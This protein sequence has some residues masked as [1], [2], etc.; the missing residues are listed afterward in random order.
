MQGIYYAG[1]LFTAAERNWNAAM[2]ERLRGAFPDLPI[3]V[4]QE[5]CTHLQNDAGSPDFGEI[6]HACRE[7]IDRSSILIAVLDGSDADSGTAWELGYA[8]AKGL[9][10]FGLRTDWRPAE[11]GSANC[12]LSRSCQAVCS[13]I[14]KLIASL[15]DAA[16]PGPTRP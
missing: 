4:P 15:Q 12:M 6:F 7:H 1:P 9:R 11:D 3:H 14:E 13:S 5:F 10:C 8:H 2:V 16:L